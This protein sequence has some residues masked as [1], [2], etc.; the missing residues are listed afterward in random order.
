MWNLIFLIYDL[1]GVSCAFSHK[2]SEDL[3][4][5]L[6]RWKSTTV[7]QSYRRDTLLSQ[8]EAATSMASAFSRN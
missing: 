5:D 7:L 6:G 2:L 8:T 4:R 1:G 3:I